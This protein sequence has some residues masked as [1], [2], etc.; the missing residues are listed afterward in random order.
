MLSETTAH[1][2]QSRGRARRAGAGAHQGLRFA[3][4][5]VSTA[6]HRR[7]RAPSS[8]RHH[9]GGADVGTDGVDRNPRSD[10]HGRGAPSSASS[11][12]RE[13]A[14]AA[15]PLSCLTLAAHRG[16]EVFTTYCEAHAGD[17]PFHAVA[18]LLRAV[19]GVTGTD[20]R[21]G[22]HPRTR[23]DS[24][25]PPPTICCCSTTW[26]ASETRRRPAPE[27]DPDARRR[28]LTSLINTAS[29]S[30]ATPT[31]YVVEDA[32]WIDDVS[33]SMLADFTAG[34]PPDA[35]AGGDHLSA[36]VPRRTHPNAPRSGHCACPAR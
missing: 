13:L 15:S 16:V 19:F 32:H 12:H 4:H 26:S 9:A 11:G 10:H 24:I 3:R 27:I 5:R 17:I 29:L 7:S 30:R 1:L 21:D 33:D 22:S 35:V 2:V 25:R 20:P 18:R 23:R 28:R 8:T 14:R 34:D 6:R 36:R 31:V